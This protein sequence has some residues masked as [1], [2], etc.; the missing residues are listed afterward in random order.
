MASD[1][2]IKALIADVH[3]LYRTGLCFLLKDRLAISEVIEV[4]CFDDAL[5]R[6]A[7]HADIGL[8]LFDLSMPGM[9]G[10][11]SLAI[12]KE[13]YPDMRVAVVSG[14]EERE[15]VQARSSKPRGSSATGTSTYPGS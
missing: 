3:G 7:S 9:N 12:V 1:K 14:S 2:T 13:T 5:D 10:P 4:S 6:L 15:H 8:A 11:P